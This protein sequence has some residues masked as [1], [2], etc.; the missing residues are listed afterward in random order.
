MSAAL[1]TLIG[2]SAAR[3]LAFMRHG[4]TQPNLD[5]L[6]CGGDLD[7]PLTEIG[8]EQ[9]AAA[10]RR[11]AA[12]GWRVDRIVASDLQRTRESAH[13]ASR[14]LGGTPVEIDAGWR[15]RALGDWNLRPIV[16]TAAPLSAGVQPPGGEAAPAFAH[17]IEHALRRTL[18]RTPPG[19][20]A[21]LVGS[22]GVARVLG[23]L[24]DAPAAAPVANGELMT[25][26]L[27]RLPGAAP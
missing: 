11:I 27:G 20:L 13:I 26:D 25:F 4:A 22:R 3:P 1:Q 9:V 15:E 12:A 8:R 23:E 17:R 14:V 21:L 2:H 7:L 16:D 24:L 19:T 18:A 10:A 6:R 5:G